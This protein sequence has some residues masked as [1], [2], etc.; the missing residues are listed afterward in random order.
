MK[1]DSFKEFVLDQLA[2][3]NPV[4]CRAMFG[5]YGLYH[6]D[7]FFGIL[8]KGRLYFKTDDSTRPAYEAYGMKPFRPSDKQTLINYYEV[9]P[10]IL[11]NEEELII[12]ARDAVQAAGNKI[13]NQPGRK[14]TRDKS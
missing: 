3:M 9:P 1:Q 2:G 5:G 8:H 14:V 11:E 6:R 7:L 4:T 12:W 10:D 13:D